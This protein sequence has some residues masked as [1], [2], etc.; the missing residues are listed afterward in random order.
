MAASSELEAKVVL[1]GLIFVLAEFIKIDY[2]IAEDSSTQKS[3]HVSYA[4]Q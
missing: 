3:A 2:Q 1:V 4:H